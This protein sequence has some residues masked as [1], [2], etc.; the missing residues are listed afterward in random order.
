MVGGQVQTFSQNLAVAAGLIEQTNEVAVFQDIFD[1]RG[2]KQ[3]FHILRGPGG[4][5]APLPETLPNLG[6]VR[7]RLF[8]FQKQMELVG[9]VPG[10]LTHAAVGGDA[11]PNLILD[12]QH[13]QFLQLLAQILDVEAHK[14]VF[15]V[16][17]GTVV[18]DIQ[19]AGHIEVKGLRH[20]VGLRDVLG[21][22][23]GVEVGED[24]HLLRAGVCQIGPVDYLH[25]PVDHRLFDRLQTVLAAHHQLTE[26]QH[27]VAF[28]RQRVFVLAV[29][30]VD[31]QR[32]YIV[33]AGGGQLDN[34]PMKPLYQGK[35]L[36]LRVTDKNIV[37]RGEE[38]ADDLGLAG[39]GLAAAGRTQL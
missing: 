39:H 3:V 34:L 24:R 23:G 36:R 20:T 31:V 15:N 9:K 13:P 21:G 22:Q 10:R 25:G 5:A 18:K 37:R 17:I 30:Q 16:H 28:Q 33:P 35:I 19:A 29:I 2:G 6:A 12:N 38:H 8:L 11:A 4:N 26:R 7:R 27:E 14:P 1:F 32:I